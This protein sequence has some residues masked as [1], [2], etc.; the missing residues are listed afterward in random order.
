MSRETASQ[1][2]K[3]LPSFGIL[4]ESLASLHVPLLQW[5]RPSVPYLVVFHFLVQRKP[6]CLHDLM[7]LAHEHRENECIFAAVE[8]Q[9]NPAWHAIDVIDHLYLSYLVLN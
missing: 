1:L 2:H 9:L 6:V 8:T 3:I 7:T 5:I 4:S